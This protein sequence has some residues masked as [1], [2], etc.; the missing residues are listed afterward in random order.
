METFC[1]PAAL[2]PPQRAKE[3]VLWGAIGV[4]APLT[5][6]P[7]DLTIARRAQN[8]PGVRKPAHKC[9][10]EE[11][12]RIRRLQQM[13]GHYVPNKRAEYYN[14]GSQSRF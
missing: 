7:D 2:F 6:P 12:G 4:R 1:Q 9:R 3:D 5:Q 10:E 11:Q 8:T 13:T 14:G